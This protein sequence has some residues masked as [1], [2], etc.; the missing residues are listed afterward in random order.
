M[1]HISC[2]LGRI[3]N[4]ELVGIYKVSCVDNCVHVSIVFV[5]CSNCVLIVY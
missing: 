5:M 2:G 1:E 3:K 4:Y